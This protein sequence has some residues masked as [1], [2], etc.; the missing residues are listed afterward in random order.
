[1]ALLALGPNMFE[2]APLN[3]QSIERTTEA[4]WAA[5]PRFGAAPGRQFTGYGEDPIRI[6]GLLFPDELGGRGEFEAIRLT[7]QAA[8]PVTMMGWAGSGMA[9]RIF[10][11]VVILSVSDQQT[12]INRQGVGR[13]LSFDI[14]VAPFVGGGK[15]IGLFG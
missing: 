12:S 14:E 15:P 10:G 8:R 2:I 5:I 6:S 13:R 9:A 1:M 4:V 11:L 7:Q 3:F